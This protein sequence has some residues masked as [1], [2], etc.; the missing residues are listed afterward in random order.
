DAPIVEMRVGALPNGGELD[1]KR[2]RIVNRRGDEIRRFTRDLFRPQH[3]IAALVAA[4]E[5]WKLISTPGATDPYA[6]IELFSPIIPVGYNG[7]NLQRCLL[8]TGYLTLMLGLLL[9]AVLSAIHLPATWPGR[10]ARGGYAGFLAALF[11]LVGNRGL[12]RNS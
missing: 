4:A 9:L 12:I 7:R 5:G 3:E 11:A 8:S 6:R 2:M 10:L 1:I